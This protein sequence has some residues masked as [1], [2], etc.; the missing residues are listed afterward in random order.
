MPHI[1]SVK[2]NLVTCSPDVKVSASNK[3]AHRDGNLYKPLTVTTARDNNTPLP[4]ENDN[5]LTVVMQNQCDNGTQPVDNDFNIEDRPIVS[6]SKGSE[7]DNIAKQL[8][9]AID[10]IDDYLDDELKVITDHRYLA[11]ILELK[12]DYNNGEK[13]WHPIGLI[14][15]D[16]RIIDYFRSKTQSR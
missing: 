4:T 13:S 1:T 15:D 6:D 3:S 11:S 7:H 12:V 2:E 8:N 16:V 9:V 5:T 10:R 14:K